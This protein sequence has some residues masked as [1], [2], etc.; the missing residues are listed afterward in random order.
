MMRVL[1]TDVNPVNLVTLQF[2]RLQQ[3]VIH[4]TSAST[5]DT[6]EYCVCVFSDG[7]SPVLLVAYHVGTRGKQKFPR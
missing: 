7:S 6:A 4:L 5:L 3:N 2:T 1:F